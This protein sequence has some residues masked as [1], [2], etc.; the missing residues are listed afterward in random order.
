MKKLIYLLAFTPLLFSCGN[1][2]KD[3]EMTL[4]DSL[5]MANGEYKNTI[6]VKDSSIEAFIRGFNE[7]QDNLDAIKEKEK[8]VTKNSGDA[9][10][11]KTKEQ[12]IVDDIQAIYDMMNQ[13]KNRIASL[14]KKL[15]KSNNKN[16]DLEKFIARLTSQ[17]EER[18]IEIASLKSSLERLNIE[19]STLNTEYQELAQESDVKTEKLNTA[20]YAFGTS[21]E[22][23]KNGVL[24]KEG[25]F[26]GIGKSQKIKEDFNKNYFTK[27]D[28]SQ[29]SEITLGA[30]K[31]KLVTTH[32]AGSYK[33]EGTD[34]KAEKLVITNAEDF[35]SASKYL[36]IVVE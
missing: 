13:N 30:K 23:I 3:G 25:G 32:P 5:R 28:I 16:A 7:I 26:I 14:K 27:V 15:D 22:L 9:E 4:E 33:I 35:W 21:K 29:L 34:G 2:T 10:L 18:D 12:E 17:L 8:I 19:L 1:N 31:A 6:A 11:R 20:Y 24:T 36:V